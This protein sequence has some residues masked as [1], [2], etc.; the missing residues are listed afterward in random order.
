MQIVIDL[1]EEEIDKLESMFACYIDGE[2]DAEYFLHELIKD[3]M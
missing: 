3:A 1:S 2:D